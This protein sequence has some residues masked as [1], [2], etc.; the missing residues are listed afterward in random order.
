MNEHST[1]AKRHVRHMVGGH[2]PSLKLKEAVFTI[3][4]PEKAGTL[5]NLLNKLGDRW[6]ISMFHYRNE[7]SIVGKGLIG[8]QIQDGTKDRLLEALN[9]V[10]YSYS[11]KEN[12]DA[13]KLFL[14]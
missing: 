6:D 1:V 9:S 7:G 12:D 11:D 2:E 8:F 14:G 5:I 4:F 13:Y 3:D 10:G